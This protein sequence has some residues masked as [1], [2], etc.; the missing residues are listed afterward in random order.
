MPV[1]GIHFQ[2]GETSLRIFTTI[3]TLGTPRENSLDEIRIEF[4]FA[5]GEVTDAM[6]LSWATWP[7]RC[8]PPPPNDCFRTDLFSH[9]T[10][11]MGRTG[12]TV[13]RE[14]WTSRTP[15]S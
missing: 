11:A 8:R 7:H 3:T 15:R 1:L 5:I 9:Q 6:C 4:F 10:A 2:R 13:E 12:L 14:L